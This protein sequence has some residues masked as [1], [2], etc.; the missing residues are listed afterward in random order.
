VLRITDLHTYYG[1]VHALRGVSLKVEE[2]D[3][4]ALIGNNGAGKSTLLKT[5][6]GLERPSSGT[7]EFLGQRIETLPSARIVNLGISQSPE[8]RRVFPHS[9]VLENLEMGAYTRSDL[10]AVNRDIEAMMER[11]PI[12]R[13]RSHQLA[14][15]LSGGEQQM[16]TIARALMSRP[17]LMMLDEPSLGLMPTLVKEIFVI[18]QEI[19]AD[20]TTILLVEQNARKALAVANRAYV[21][22][23][24]EIVLEGPA[25][26]LRNLDQVRKAYL[27][28]QYSVAF[29]SALA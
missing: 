5:V 23:T 26:Q 7:I 13:Q 4:V 19:H 18:I 21:L 8:G 11:F 16:L 24:G 15:T 10:R 1:H 12:L 29:R 17:K 20:G 22:E 25:E 9:T 28:E 6:S 2:G 27:G 14:G 3:I